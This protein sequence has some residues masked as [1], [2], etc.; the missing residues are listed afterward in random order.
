M[1]YTNEITFSSSSLLNEHFAVFAPETRAYLE[2]LGGRF[3]DR[4][5]FAAIDGARRKR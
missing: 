5:V 4:D 3:A 2:R 1:F